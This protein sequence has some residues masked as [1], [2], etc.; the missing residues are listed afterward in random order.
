MPKPNPITSASGSAAHTAASTQNR[1]GILRVGQ[2]VP[3]ARAAM[4]CE[5]IVGTRFLSGVSVRVMIPRTAVK[6]THTLKKRSPR[7]CLGHG[8]PQVFGTSGAAAAA[9][10][11]SHID[12]ADSEAQTPQT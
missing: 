4:L 5:K 1:T 10:V 12:A 11:A 9:S 3:N 2:H 6:A 8:R 7:L